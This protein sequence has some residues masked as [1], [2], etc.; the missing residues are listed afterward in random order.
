MKNC[1]IKYKKLN[2]VEEKKI[3]EEILIPL[4]G[5]KKIYIWVCIAFIVFIINLANLE[6]NYQ[7]LSLS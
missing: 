4:L 1:K 3:T 2:K 7:R 5:F 6:I